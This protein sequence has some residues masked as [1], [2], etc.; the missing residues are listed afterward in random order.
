MNHDEER[1]MH[2][3]W[4]LHTV[5]AHSTDYHL[6]LQCVQ[7]GIVGYE[8]SHYATVELFCMASPCVTS[9]TRPACT[10]IFE[11]DDESQTDYTVTNPCRVHI[12]YVN[13]KRTKKN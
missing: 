10:C 12:A 7:R 4:S 1:M 11:W 13:M 9:H 2:H 3:P 6:Q 8:A 5:W